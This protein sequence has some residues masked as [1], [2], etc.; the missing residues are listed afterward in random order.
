MKPY[1]LFFNQIDA[2]SLSY[3]G[4][5][6]ANLGEMTQA[7]FPVPG[8]FCI[9]TYAYKEFVETSTEMSAFF[10]ALDQIELAD[11]EQ[12]RVIAQQIRTHVE[13][14]PIPLSIKD[15]IIQAWAKQGTENFYA[16]RSSATAED[17]PGASFAGQQDTYLNVKGQEELLWHVRKCWASLFTDRAI[18]YRAKN[19]FDHRNIYL[20]VVVQQL[21]SPDTAGI[22]FTADPVNGNRTVVSIDA[23]FGLGEALVSGQVSADLYKVKNSHIVSKKL[24]KKKLAIYALPEGGTVTKEI[25]PEQQDQQALSDRQISEL[26]VL[27]KKIEQHYGVP[28]DIEFCVAKDEIYI[29]Q[30]RPITTLY[31][32]PDMPQRP[33]RVLLSFGHIQM[34]TNAMKPLGLSV[35]QHI[36]PASVFNLAGG[37]VFIDLTDILHNPI[38]R[39]VVP[40]V[41]KNVDESMSRAVAAVTSRPDFLE[42]SQSAHN[43][44]FS[45]VRKIAVP[46]LRKG[47]KVLRSGNLEHILDEVAIYTREHQKGIQQALDGKQGAERIIIVQKQLKTLLLDILHNLIPYVFPGIISV[48]MLKKAITPR[49]GH[50]DEINK[51]NKSLP[52]NVTSEM[53]LELGDLADLLRELPAVQEYLKKADDQTFYSGLDGIAGGETFRRAFAGFMDKYGMRCPGEIDMTVT[54]WYEAPTRLNSALFSHLQSLRAGEHRLR[55]A[56]GQKEAETA[57]HIMLDSVKGK[58]FRS[59]II[60]RLI[61]VYRQLGGLREQHKYILIAVMAECKKAIMEEADILV[62]QGILRESKDVYFLTLDELVNLLQHN[63]AGNVD[64][65]IAKRME[66]HGRYQ[67]LKPPRVMTSEGEIVIV[68]LN[69]ENVSA[70]MIIGSPVSAGVAEGIARVILRPES[71]ILR[72]GEILVAPHTDPGWTPLF[73]SAVAVITEVGGLMT[74]GAVVAREYGIPAVVGVDD[75]TTLIKDGEKIRVNGDLGYIEILSPKLEERE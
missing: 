45:S 49:L 6:G 46:I 37:R 43:T 20:S 12:V 60:K 59:K 69:K 36:F 66:E 41:L 68:P 30:S 10:T 44:A 67:N 31:P 15:A 40:S 24:A 61:A 74:H 63:F 35:L 5:K 3:V 70:G 19:G 71:A 33:L 1:V 58:Y 9:T 23:S 13:Q 48:F 72:E 57:M 17:L 11:L 52:H 53:G 65:L 26:A 51:L 4:G 28:Q 18:V 21:I 16:V 42:E 39:K 55:F 38:A 73:Q 22:M 2:S 50:D 8:G 54:R 34:A 32:R 64:E 75:A 56:E 29:V 27:G 62:Q 14:I 47:W 7:G 25:P